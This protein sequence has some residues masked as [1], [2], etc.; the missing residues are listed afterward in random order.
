MLIPI[1][2]EGTNSIDFSEES[3]IES[4]LIF[5]SELKISYRGVTQKTQVADV[6]FN[7]ENAIKPSASFHIEIDEGDDYYADDEDEDDDGEADEKPLESFKLKTRLKVNLPTSELQYFLDNLKTDFC[8]Y[9]YC[10]LTE[11]SNLVLD[12]TYNNFDIDYFEYSYLINNNQARWY[13]YGLQSIAITFLQ[14]LSI[15]YSGQL[16][17][18][19]EEL[20]ESAARA[21]LVI[22]EDNKDLETVLELV[23]DLRCALREKIDDPTAAYD[24]SNLWQRDS[25]EFLTAI[26]TFSKPEQKELIDKYDHL[27]TN[28]DIASGLKWGEDK[29]GAI[30]KGFDPVQNQIEDVAAMFLKLKVLRSHKLEQILITTLIFSEAIAFG[31]NLFA[32]K[33]SSGITATPR[34]ISSKEIDDPSYFQIIIKT[35]TETGKVMGLEAIKLVSTFFIAFFV[36]NE[37]IMATWIVTTGYTVFRWWRQVFIA[38]LTP[39]NKGYALLD[40]MIQIYMISSNYNFDANLLKE[41]LLEISKEGAVFSPYL[42]ALLDLQINKQNSS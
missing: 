7:F 29:F 38:S 14:K 39:E 28:I 16:R 10:N 31:R 13:R 36:T 37:N 5:K 12:K 35:L 18:I 27:W 19:I 15:G 25:T 23:R 42:F 40:K 2:S 33:K 17:Q 1:A 34:F 30:S 20:S 24:F 9:I 32:K 11:K 4:K 8:V 26:E 6:T 22:D 3:T 41:R 21:D